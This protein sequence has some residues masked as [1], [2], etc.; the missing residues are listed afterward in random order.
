MLVEFFGLIISHE[1]RH[2]T[3]RAGNDA[4][5]C[6]QATADRQSPSPFHVTFDN[7]PERPF[8]RLEIDFFQPYMGSFYQLEDLGNGEKTDQR[9]N[10]GDTAVER[11][12]EDEAG[13]AHE[14][15]IADSGEEHPQCASEQTF[16]HGSGGEAGY[17][18]YPEN[19]GPEQFGGAETHGEIS[20]GGREQNHHYHA[21][22]T[23][24]QGTAERNIQG[25]FRFSFFDH[26]RSVQKR[27][28]VGWRAGNPKQDGGN[29]TSRHG[30]CVYGSQ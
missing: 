29:G 25:F 23:A 7:P 26:T 21:E 28:N 22:Q 12:M 17:D 10:N 13:Y 15:A 18:G 4:D 6:A 24:N 16:Q 2:L 19:S 1:S 14:L 5:D 30:A 8:L 20:Q 11:F 27:G 3:A 9:G